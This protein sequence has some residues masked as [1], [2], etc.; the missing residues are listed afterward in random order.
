MQGKTCSSESKNMHAYSETYGRATRS[1][2]G[3]S[4]PCP[5]TLRHVVIRALETNSNWGMTVLLLESQ[6]YKY[7]EQV[8]P[9]SFKHVKYLQLCRG[10]Y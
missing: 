4:I 5:R 7:V 9:H 1:D 2:V 3:G 8:E 6:L 10:C